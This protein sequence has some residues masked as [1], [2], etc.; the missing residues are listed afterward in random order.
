MYEQTEGMYLNRVSRVCPMISLDFLVNNELNLSLNLTDSCH[1]LLSVL[2]QR[3]TSTY[4]HPPQLLLF[5]LT[6]PLLFLQFF[7]WTNTDIFHQV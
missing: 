7:P 2:L 4:I 5:L 3:R 6:Q 1:S